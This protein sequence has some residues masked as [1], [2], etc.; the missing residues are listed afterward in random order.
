FT[1]APAHIPFDGA[2]ANACDPKE[3]T[4]TFHFTNPAGLG[5]A[6]VDP[7]PLSE[8]NGQGHNYF[9]SENPYRL[10]SWAG[11]GEIYYQVLPDVKLTGGLRWTDDQKSFDVIPSWTLDQGKGYAITGVVDQ[12]W[13]EWTGRFNATWTPKLDFTDQSLLYSTYSRGYKGGGAN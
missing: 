8:I 1:P 13:K 7:N 4:P 9:R 6:Y 11:F 10:F 5:C 3:V 12:Q 2:L